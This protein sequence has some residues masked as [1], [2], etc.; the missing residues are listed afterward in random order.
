MSSQQDV[1]DAILRTDFASF[2]ARVFAEISGG[3]IFLANWHVNA[4]AWQLERIKRGDN[5]R[6]IVTMP[7]RYLKSIAISVAWPAWRL[8]HDPQLRL[9]CVSYSS[10]LAAKHANDCR[11][12]MQTDW[13]Q[14]I[15]P[16]AR[17]QKGGMAEMDFRTT[18]GGG[19]LSTSV[20]GTLT[21]RGG[22]IIIIDDPIK[23][24]DAHSETTRKNV[25]TWYSNT[26][27]SRLN[28]KQTGSMVL[29][30]QRLHEEDLAG[31]LLQAGGWEHLSLPAIAEDDMSIQVGP[32]QFHLFRQDTALHPERENLAKLQD[33][34]KTM[35]TATFSA[36]YQQDPVPTEG[37]HLKKEWFRYYPEQPQKLPGDLI[38]QSWDTATKEGVFNDF[39][40]C[41]TALVRGRE[42]FLLDV[43]REKLA[44]P[45]LKKRVIAHAQKHASDVLLIEDAASGASL[46]QVLKDEKPRGV[47]QPIKIKPEADKITR[48][49]AQ[50]T[51]IENSELLLPKD[52]VWL[53]EFERELL[54]FPNLRHDDQVDALTQ[55]LA[56][57]RPPNSRGPY[58]P[59]SI[60]GILGP[61]VVEG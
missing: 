8:G 54:G 23:P 36:Q 40:V 3:D 5:T 33:L 52:A 41:V 10:D 61:G 17:L 49:A 6:L 14:R 31:H 19:R 51:R 58:I 18:Q 42:V 48:F 39:S 25:L 24:D 28:N 30:M 15:F 53:G 47:P 32:N 50:S 37:L 12:V 29:V 20:G 27:V 1:L 59:G 38:V 57:P 35:G 2:V 9:V 11:S 34:K 43:I 22:D 4:I 21:G 56:W 16:K 26:L 44:F 13:Y 7:P 45:K 60:P 55:L 46:I